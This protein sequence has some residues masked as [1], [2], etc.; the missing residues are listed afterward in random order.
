M[1][2]GWSKSL[3][4]ITQSI[5]VYAEYKKE[6]R[7]YDI[8]YL[9]EQGNVVEVRNLK[10]GSSVNQD[11]LAPEKESNILLN[12]EFLRWGEKGQTVTGELELTPVYKIS[13][14]FSGKIIVV[15]V[16]IF[17]LSLCYIS[18]KKKKEK[19]S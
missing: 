19:Y 10:F 14:S 17:I 2:T 13:L 4:N 9:D 1:F 6:V 7:S 5:S 18:H 15:A 11:V 3:T 12:Y 8:T 16:I